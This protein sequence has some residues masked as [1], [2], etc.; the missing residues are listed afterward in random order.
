MYKAKLATLLV[1]VLSAAT[2]ALAPMHASATVQGLDILTNYNSAKCM[3]VYAGIANVGTNI[4]QKTCN[5]GSLS[6]QFQYDTTT[7]AGYFFLRS[8]LNTSRCVGI[9]Q[10]SM[11]DGAYAAVMDCGSDATKFRLFQPAGQIQK[12]QNLRSGKCLQVNNGST[13]ENAYISQLNCNDNS[14]HFFWQ[15]T[16]VNWS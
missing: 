14:N 9:W 5:T 8:K 4:V 16:W 3:A 13:A 6:Q 2:L 15:F 11:L 10:S 7:P 12:L 1:A